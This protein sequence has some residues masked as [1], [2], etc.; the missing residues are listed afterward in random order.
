M[1]VRAKTG[2]A[3]AIDAAKQLSFPSSTQLSQK[4]EGA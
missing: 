2:T 3:R 1:I 4:A